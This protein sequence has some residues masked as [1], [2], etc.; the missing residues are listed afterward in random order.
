M[1]ICR[2][3]C[4][5][6]LSFLAWQSFQVWKINA[7][8]KNL[9]FSRHVNSSWICDVKIDLCET[10]KIFLFIVAFGLW[11]EPNWKAQYVWFA[12][13]IVNLN[14]G[15]RRA[16]TCYP[17]YGIDGFDT[18][19]VDDWKQLEA[20]RF[21]KWIINQLPFFDCNNSVALMCQKRVVIAALA[22]HWIALLLLHFIKIFAIDGAIVSARRDIF[23]ELLNTLWGVI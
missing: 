17:H 7:R 23:L 13:W 9:F 3:V 14:Y 6:S 2:C 8:E 12:M 18:Q 15:L 5:F 22:H 10:L 20:Y 1:C 19:S 4:V 16:W 21:S 11:A